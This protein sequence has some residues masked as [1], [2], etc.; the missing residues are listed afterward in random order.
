MSRIDLGQYC[1]EY[2][3]NVELVNLKLDEDQK[4]RS[5]YEHLS[6]EVFGLCDALNL[7]AEK[8]EC[9]DRCLEDD[10]TWKVVIKRQTITPDIAKEEVEDEV[11]YK[12]EL[13]EHKPDQDAILPDNEYNFAEIYFDHINL[14]KGFEG[15]NCSWEKKMEGV[16]I[17]KQFVEYLMEQ[18]L[19]E[20]KE[21]Y[22][23][24]IK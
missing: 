6:S 8:N 24:F 3:K 9:R 20:D 2:K 13:V 19:E 22:S 21:A 17:V 11:Y 18:K 23:Q 10:P 1:Q 14:G 16:R 7:E 15:E 12:L 5:E 4:K